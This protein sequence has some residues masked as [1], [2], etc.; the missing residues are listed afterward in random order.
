[1][2]NKIAG[3]VAEWN[4]FH[5]G[6]ETMIEELKEN[7]P[8]MAIF[9]VMSG[10]FVQRGEPALFDSWTRAK[11]AV[12]AGADA[13]FELPVLASLQSADR[14]AEEGAR[15]LY[16]L[17]C[18]A[19]Y[20]G[21]ESLE[22]GELEEAASYGLTEEWTD[23]LHQFLKEGLSYAQA[24]AK[25]MEVHSLHL[26][27]EL[28]KPNNLL[29]Y[30]YATAILAHHWPLSIHVFHRDMEHNISAT[31]A[32]KELLEKGA[33]SLLSSKAAEEAAGL[34]EQGNFTDFHRY[35]EACLLASRLMDE[36]ALSATGLFTEGLEHKWF[37]ESQRVSYKDMLD[38]IKSKRYLYSRLKRIGA[39]LLIG[40][41][42]PSPFIDGEIPSYAR[43]LALRREKSRLLNDISIPLI[44]SM[45]KALRTL[46]PIITASLLLDIRASDIRS[47]CLHGEK[48][49]Q[50]RQEFYRSPIVV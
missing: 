12:D 1:M 20:F 46:P 47:W 9:S 2:T 14:F 33:T 16:F 45:A 48:Y 42:G 3:I 41:A 40:G 32:R 27:R 17:G 34:M 43:L 36:K 11:W 24:S 21:T 39:Q 7:N 37:R 49:R 38:H 13:V 26:A 19:I 35:E 31:T 4:P 29:G 15:L 50:A 18:G 25:A 5:R 22:A 10:C 44:T 8:D 30:R 6:H 23:S 28:T